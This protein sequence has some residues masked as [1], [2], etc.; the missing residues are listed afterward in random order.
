MYINTYQ[1]IQ[2]HNMPEYICIRILLPLAVG[3]CQYFLAST[4][5]P[6]ICKNY[7]SNLVTKPWWQESDSDSP[8]DW[9]NWGSVFQYS[10]TDNILGNIRLQYNSF[11]TIAL[12]SFKNSDILY[13]VLATLFDSR[14][15]VSS[16]HYHA[17]DFSQ[18]EYTNCA[19]SYFAKFL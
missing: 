17:V 16:A 7:V 6:S 14:K 5:I 3:A 10:C 18:G 12:C 9:S 2:Q 4:F 13:S 15:W 8:C 11:P 19:Y 1:S